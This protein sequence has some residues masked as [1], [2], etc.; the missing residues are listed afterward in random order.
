MDS[1][2][3]SNFLSCEKKAG[4]PRLAAVGLIAGRLVGRQN[5]AGFQNLENP[6][7]VI[8][9]GSLLCLQQCNVI[10]SVKSA[11]QSVFLKQSVFWGVLWCVKFSHFFHVNPYYQVLVYLM[12]QIYTRENALL[13]SAFSHHILYYVKSFATLAQK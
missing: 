9:L 4:S 6:Q 10:N 5:M 12:I 13:I 11:F 8:L 1:Y 7:Q 2:L 3:D